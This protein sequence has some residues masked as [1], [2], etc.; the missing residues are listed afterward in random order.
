MLLLDQTFADFVTVL[1]YA[2]EHIAGYRTVT[3]HKVDPPYIMPPI[4]VLLRK[5]NKLLW[6]GKT[7]SAQLITI[8]IAQMIVSV[9]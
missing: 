4:V 6:C 5:R 8:K 3:V 9:E 1:Q 2:L 7:D